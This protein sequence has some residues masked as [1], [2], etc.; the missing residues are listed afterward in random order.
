M[1]AVKKVKKAEDAKRKEREETEK[2]NLRNIEKM[3]KT[4]A[5]QNDAEHLSK[6]RVMKL[7]SRKPRKVK[8]VNRT[9]QQL[10]EAQLDYIRY[11][12]NI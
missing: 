2:R 10:T 3:K 6:V 5:I 11:V 4:E 1:E 7:R 8:L 12:E 9:E